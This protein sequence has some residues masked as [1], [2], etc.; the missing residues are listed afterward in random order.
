MFL[1][2]LGVGGGG[3]P[4]SV[5]CNAHAFVATSGSDQPSRYRTSCNL[6]NALLV[7]LILREPSSRMEAMRNAKNNVKDMPHALFL[8]KSVPTKNPTNLDS[9]AA[10]K[11]RTSKE[12]L[13]AGH[14]YR[15]NILQSL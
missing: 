11:Q 2:I 7:N 14:D 13:T 10:Q 4:S 8:R 12:G 5:S 1:R 6:C 9:Q 15:R 3:A